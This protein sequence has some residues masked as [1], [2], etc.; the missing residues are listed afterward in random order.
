MTN[1]ILRGESDAENSNVR[2]GAGEVASTMP[3]CGPR[4]CKTRGK[5]A[6]AAVLVSLTASAWA[7]RRVYVQMETADLEDF[8]KSVEIARRFGATHVC[9]NQIEPS[10][11]QWDAAMNRKD[12]YPNWTMHRPSFFKFYV[13]EKLR[14]YLPADYANRNLEAVRA[15]G[16]ILRRHGLKAVYSAAID[17]SY[18]PEQVYVD[19]P[20]W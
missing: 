18:L 16:E 12:P 15:R 14:K 9:A 17:P 4:L 11:W 6:V 1:A 19:H 20:E 13:P 2:F 8:E 5:A 10:M 3:L 7:E